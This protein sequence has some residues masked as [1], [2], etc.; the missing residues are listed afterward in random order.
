MDASAAGVARPA[1]RKCVLSSCGCRGRCIPTL[2]PCVSSTAETHGRQSPDDRRGVGCNE[3]NGESK[4][5]VHHS[6]MD[7]G[8]E[9]E[10]D[11]GGVVCD[12]GHGE[13]EIDHEGQGHIGI[14]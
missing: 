3:A 9:E 6:D 4:S 2:R 13:N 7:I 5:D 8:N 12:D 10:T 14:D 11:S 1:G